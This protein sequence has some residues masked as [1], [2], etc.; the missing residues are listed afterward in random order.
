MP[1]FRCSYL[2]D[3]AVLTAMID[4]GDRVDAAAKMAALPWS[5]GNGPIGMPVRVMRARD[6][7][8][9]A[10]VLALASSGLYLGVAAGHLK[11]EGQKFQTFAG[12]LIKPRQTHLG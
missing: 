2:V 9:I 7:L 8:A 3:G 11:H 10:A 1:R 5:T 4:A 12:H 6:R